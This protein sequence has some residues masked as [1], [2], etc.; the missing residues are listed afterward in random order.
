MVVVKYADATTE[1]VA[2]GHSWDIYSGFLR[3]FEEGGSIVRMLILTNIVDVKYT[4]V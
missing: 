2:E 3:I 4:E 1:R